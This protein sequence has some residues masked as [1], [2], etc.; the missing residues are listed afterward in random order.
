MK[1]LSVLFLFLLAACSQEYDVQETQNPETANR[2]PDKGNQN[3]DP[4]SLFNLNNVP[5]ITLQFSEAQWNKILTNF[6]LNP[7]N[8]KKVVAAFTFSS[9]EVNIQLDSIGLKLKG[10]TSRRRPEGAFGQ[11]HNAQ[12]PDWHHC[13]F[14]LDFSKNRPNQLFYGRNKLA[15]KWF[16]DDAAYAREIYSYDLFRRFGIWTAPLASYCRVYIKV[17]GTQLANYGVYAMIESVDEDFIRERQGYW[18]AAVGDMWKGGFG[19]DGNKADFVQ[20]ASMGIED[21][22]LNP[23][24]SVFYAYDLKTNEDNLVSAKANLTQFISDLNSKT[25][26]D[27]KN[28]ISSKM[29][30]PLFMRT[31]AV[32]VVLGM[33]DDYWGNGNNFY[34]Y[35]S[36]NGKAYFI[37]YDYDNTLGTSLLISNSGTQNPLGWGTTGKPLITKILTIPEYQILYKNAIK[38]L[39]NPNNNYF[40]ATK[41]MARIRVWHEKINLYVAND[42][43]E[44]MVIEDKPA[45]WGNQP[46]Y[47]LLSGNNQAG[48]NGPA[49]FFSSRAANIPW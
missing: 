8:E 9:R 11:L 4:K 10:N 41:S 3:I 29:D 1:K 42:T 20:T 26:I 36:P 33:W 32:N 13:H 6:D 21:V 44:D 40:S 7:Q 48:N 30:V 2:L 19:S 34:F 12:N 31:Y 39:I 35:F 27:F 5:S 38:E 15:L 14:S 23:A 46:N 37:P 49:N 45:S 25:G 22:T 28:W 18:S 17:D 16:K 43:G 47:R 24:T